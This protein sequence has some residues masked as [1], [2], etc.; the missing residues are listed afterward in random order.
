[1]FYPFAKDSI[2]LLTFISRL[3]YF[4][5]PALVGLFFFSKLLREERQKKVEEPKEENPKVVS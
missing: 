3:A 1:M 4:Y 5:V 2:A